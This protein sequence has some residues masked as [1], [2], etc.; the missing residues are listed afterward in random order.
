[1]NTTLQTCLQQR[2]A[3]ESVDNILRAMGYSERALVRAGKRLQAVLADPDLGL[4]AGRYD[5]RFSSREFLRALAGAVSVDAKETDRRIDDI[6]RE[7]RRLRQLFKPWIFV[8]T[9]FKR[10]GEPIFLLAWTEYMRRLPLPEKAC[11]LSR[12]ELTR[13][14][15]KRIREHYRK[16]E[17]HLLLWGAISEYKLVVSDAEQVAMDREGNVL[18]GE[19]LRL[20]GSAVMTLR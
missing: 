3:S 8:D 7:L 5:F 13:F 17:G 19:P 10:S 20:G 14:A 6:E 18:H 16:T 15:A 2:V 1:M 9:Q 12:D 4:G 11:L